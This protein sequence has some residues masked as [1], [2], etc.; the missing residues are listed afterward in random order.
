MATGVEIASTTVEVTTTDVLEGT[1]QDVGLRVILESES[2]G[3]SVNGDDLWEVTAFLSSNSD[4]SG[5]RLEETTLTLSSDQA[6]TDISAGDPSEISGLTFP[7]TL[8]GGPTTCSDFNYVCV[9]IVQG[10]NP[11][12]SYLLDSQPENLISCDMVSCRGAL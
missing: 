9:E 7:L 2:G 12:P 8:Q 4:G 5:S 1:Q 6:G 3:G 10:S 11:T